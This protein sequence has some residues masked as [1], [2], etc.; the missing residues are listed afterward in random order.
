MASVE[1]KET[2]AA[3]TFSKPIKNYEIDKFSGSA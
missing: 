3:N 1:S 2:A